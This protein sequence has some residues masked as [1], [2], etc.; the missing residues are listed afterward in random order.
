MSREIRDYQKEFTKIKLKDYHI[1]FLEDKSK[2]V[3][4]NYP[5]G[6]GKTFLLVAKVIKENVEWE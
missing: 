5:R 4:G 3:I 1:E 2:I 6:G